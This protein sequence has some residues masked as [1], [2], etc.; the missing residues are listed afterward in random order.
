MKQPSEFGEPEQVSNFFNVSMTSRFASG[1]LLTG[2]VDTGQIVTD[3]CFV[4]DSPQQLLN[5][6]VVTPYQT[7][8]QLKLQGSYP[9][10]RD[11]SVSGTLKTPP[12]HSIRRTMR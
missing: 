8:T 5:C 9:L 3:N 11:F 1:L 10:P 6:R 2:G 4:V 7:R 12:D